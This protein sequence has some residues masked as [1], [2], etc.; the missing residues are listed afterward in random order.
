MRLTDQFG[1]DITLE[2]KV[3]LTAWTETV[4]GFLAHG[5][6]TASYLETA[7]RQDP[8]FALGHAARGLFLLLLARR[9]LYD[10]A[11][12]CW[13]IANSSAKARPVTPREAAVIAALR[14]WLDGWPSHSAMLLDDALAHAPRD[15]MLLKL[16]HAIHFITGNSQGMRASIERVLPD[17]AEE[18][19]SFGFVLG[20]HAFALEET[21]DYRHAEATGRKA[22]ACAPN[23][24]WGL[25]AVAHVHDMTGRAEEGIG[26][27]ES[28]PDA[29]S[30][31]NNFGYHVWW[32]LALMYLER[33]EIDK[34]L[35]LYDRKVRQDRTD[36]F[37]DISNATSLLSR[38]ELEGINVGSRW[39]ELAKISDSRAEDGCNVFADLHYLL[40]L[41]NGGRRQGTDRLIA[42]LRRRTEA[43]GDLQ[44]ISVATGL[45]AALGLE[46]YRNGNYASAFTLLAS[47]RDAL[48]MIGG[49]HA[50]RDVFERITIDAAIRAGFPEEA[51]TI[52]K[53][54]TRK[55]GGSDSFAEQRLN[56][57][58]RM[59][60]A[61]NIMQDERL[62]ATPA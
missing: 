51:E 18:H 25:H 22:L 2:D 16:A 32:H 21:G 56:V 17:Y 28:R 36:D 61:S 43:E 13:K 34:V 35:D 5:A 40:A 23:D 58:E 44:K 47:A 38:L 7:L 45:P 3:A 59:Q 10:T 54:R 30:H 4:N 31:C 57:C 49:S 6:T 52:L 60:R 48:P 42:D 41:L 37:R 14:S 55:R 46:Q 27:L 53:D 26:W 1:Y 19:P 20:C 62:R 9:E 39:E 24:A 11:F 8:E 15:A 50:Q 33:G 29:W 12:E